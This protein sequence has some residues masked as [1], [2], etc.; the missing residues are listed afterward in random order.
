MLKVERLV[1]ITLLL[2]T[3]GKMTAERLADIM[4][5]SVRTIYRDM[6]ALSLAHVPVTM[7]YGPGGGYYLP[8]DYHLDATVFSSEEAVALA[9]G[10]AVVGGYRL[11]E[12]GDGL[13]RALFKLEAALPEEYRADVRA[14]RE[15]FLFDTTAWHE[16]PTVTPHLEKL[17]AAVWTERQVDLLYP[18]SDGSGSHWRRVEPHGLVCKA[19]VWYLVAYCHM[20]KDFRTFRVDRVD[21]L[22]VAEKP[23]VPRPKFDLETYWEEARQRFEGL[24]MP[25]SLTLS[26][27]PEALRRIGSEGEV[28]DRQPDGRSLVRVALESARSAIQYALSLGSEVVVI[29]PPEVRIGVAA[30]ARAVAALYENVAFETS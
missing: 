24:A 4:G 16:R 22:A 15:R 18:R 6:D 29:E 8:D 9:L 19:G 3:R 2:Q 17:R 12:S 1:A 14:A 7:D 25:F 27:T 26:A 13:R 10:G 28:L 23:V 20:R 5:V 30:A 21:E 11:F